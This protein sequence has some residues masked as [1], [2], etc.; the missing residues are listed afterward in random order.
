LP[1]DSWALCAMSLND[2]LLAVIDLVY[3]AALE[4]E[5]WPKAL[6]ELAD[7]MGADHVMIGIHDPVTN[8]FS[9]I[10]PRTD[11]E[12]V[13]SYADHWADRNPLWQRSA[14]L[15]VGRVFSPDTLM[16]RAEF[17]ATPFYNEWWRPNRFGLATLG[18]NVLVDGQASAMAGI[19]RED[20][21]E[22][23]TDDQMRFFAAAARHMARAA[24]I[25]RQL[26]TLAL[27]DEMALLAFETM[28]QGAFLVDAAAKVLHANAAGRAALDAADGLKLVGG[29]LTAADESEMLGRLIASCGEGISTASGP[30]GEFKI[31]SGARRTELKVVVTP[32]K[33]RGTAVGV[34]WLGLR[35]PVA[36][37]TL[38]DLDGARKRLEQR[39]R[40]RYGLTSAEAGLAS[41]IA[42]GDGREAAAQRRGIS[43]STARAHLSSI[44][45]KTGTHR[46]A[47][48]VHL[49]AE[50]ENC[51]ADEVNP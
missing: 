3:A 47:E 5:L 32:L 42:K 20:D 34:P 16:Q 9:N 38:S 27:R 28:P 35:R 29:R 8:F 44:F 45:E 13:I 2:R 11:P 25:H 10:A 17:I 23:F 40:D 30:G 46:Q 31:R 24:K 26:R 21:K 49:L 33:G 6:T 51:T 7:G 1:I 50:M 48:L 18:V 19:V 37:V 12:A 15:P 14:A 39:M 22:P 36:T 43:V 41:E 4:G